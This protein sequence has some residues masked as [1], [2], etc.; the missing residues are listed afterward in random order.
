VA[1]NFISDPLALQTEA[2]GPSGLVVA[3]E[4]ERQLLDC[5]DHIGGNL[6]GSIYAE[7]GDKYAAVERVLRRRVGRLTND[8][9]PTGV[10]VSPAMV[11][12]GPFPSTGHAGFTAVGPPATLRRFSRLRCYDGVRPARLPRALR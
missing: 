5:L 11:H 1:A 4:D 8:K 2:F 7:D 10:A 9:M 6:V 3:C 12:G